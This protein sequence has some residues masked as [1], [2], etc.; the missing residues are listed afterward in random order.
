MSH[1]RAI[2]TIVVAGGGIVGLSAAIAFARVLPG[3]AVKVVET[4]P[5]PAALADRLPTAHPG[6]TRFHAF[7][8]I[9]ETDLVR[10]GVAT[11]H[12]GT[13]FTDWSANGEPWIWAFGS[14]GKPAGAIP[15][16]QVWVRAQ[17][18]GHALPYDRYSIAAALA[19]AGKFVHPARDPEF[20]GS[21][22]TYGLRLNPEAYQQRL[23]TEAQRSRVTFQRGEI[24]GLE[25][26]ED[27]RASALVL[28]EGTRIEADLFVDCAGPAGR[29]IR[30]LDDSFEDWSG[31]MPFGRLS[32][33]SSESELIP[34]T[35]DVARAAPRGW[36]SELSLRGRTL[37]V[38]M[39]EQGDVAVVRGRRL[40][41]WVHNVLALGDSA[42]AVDPLQGF[43]L[44][45][46]QIS[47]LLALEM[48]PG[49]DFADIETGEYNR[50]YERITRRVRDFLALHYSRSGRSGGLWLDVADR[51]PPDSLRRTLDQYEYRGRMPFHEDESVSRDSWTAVLLGLGVRPR[52]LDPRAGAVPLDQAMTAMEH[53]ASDIAQMPAQL[54]KYGDYLARITH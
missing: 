36:T 19:Q 8:G 17:R 40:R 42:T 26:G 13:A 1:D 45:L 11:H 41:P 27:G 21:R 3:T 16:D 54:P 48:L 31:W 52:E 9:D 30:K 32:L 14:Y 22:F 2:R 37:S 35:M 34:R 49:R 53:L 28:T 38:S 39:G 43:N 4:T 10:S 12:L 5:D 47:I 7:I 23:R 33:S 25:I 18:A 20:V 15:F 51:E 6:V 46:A 50:R 29:L 24:G 44:E